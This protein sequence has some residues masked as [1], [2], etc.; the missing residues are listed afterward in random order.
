MISDKKMLPANLDGNNY[1]MQFASLSEK[2]NTIDQKLDSVKTTSSQTACFSNASKNG[3]HYQI[4]P[5]IALTTIFTGQIIAV[6]NDDISLTPHLVLRGEW[7]ME[8]TQICESMVTQMNRPVI[9]DI[10]ANFGWYGLTLS[11]FDSGSSIHFFEANPR[12]I[13]PLKKTTLV[14]GISLR[15]RINNRAVSRASNDKIFLHIPLMHKGSASVQSF[16]TNLELF[17]ENYDDL[18]VIEV[19][20]ISIDDYCVANSLYSVDFMKIDVEG[21]EA[22][23]LMGAR[24]TIERSSSLVVFMEWNCARYP[25]ALLGILTQFDNCTIVSSLGSQVDL[26]DL[27]HS[28]SSILEFEEHVRVKI[29]DQSKSYFDIF[30][31]KGSGRD[32]ISGE[33]NDASATC[34]SLPDNPGGDSG[35][36]IEEFQREIE[37][38]QKNIEDL[39]TQKHDIERQKEAA[40]AALSSVSAQKHDIERQKEAAEAALSSVSAQK[41]DIERQKEAAEAALSSVSAEAELLLVQLHQMR[42]E[43]DQ[44]FIDSQRKEEK[45]SW[46]RSQHEIMAGMLKAYNELQAKSAIINRLIGS[47]S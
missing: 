45:L 20:T 37:G 27:L 44:A 39:L 11:R 24:Q 15:S 30:L 7:E 47:F 19:E 6:A 25:D 40:E 23:V 29:G 34:S 9:F 32:L 43:L 4:S 28:S 22:D 46:L 17:H 36:L 18:E 13:E 12:L 38:Y 33:C 2:L 1:D 35:E 3:L 26:T 8:L 41:Q 5:T 21:A 14:N 31:R 42:Y 16:N 10:G